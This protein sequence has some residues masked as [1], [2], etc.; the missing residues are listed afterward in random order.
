MF[1]ANSAGEE[2]IWDMQI[3]THALLTGSAA[4]GK[5]VAATVPIFAA[6]CCPDL[7]DLIIVDPTDEYTWAAQFPNTRR[8]TSAGEVN[9]CI[10]HLSREL[11]NRH[12]LLRQRNAPN[13][14]ILRDMYTA[15]LERAAEDGPAPKRLLGVFDDIASFD[16]TETANAH[17]L[18]TTQNCA[19]SVSTTLSSR[20]G[21]WL[22]VGTHFNLPS[23]RRFLGTLRTR[24]FE[25]ET[26]HQYKSG[27]L[28]PR[29]H[30]WARANAEPLHNPVIA[31]RYLPAT[32]RPSPW[33]RSIEL[34]GARDGRPAANRHPVVIVETK[35]REH[36]GAPDGFSGW[37][38]R[39]VPLLTIRGM[40]RGLHAR[41]DRDEPGS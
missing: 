31:V 7:F 41:A 20:L 18:L 32:T 16:L 25:R 23:L 10:E 8:L 9:D 11:N 4:G 34:K 39:S 19:R 5:T 3:D 24:Q 35:S 14:A 29:G 30:A 2:A 36:D 37:P 1:G 40:P 33:E 17:L 6:L 22:I 12:E 27:A 15:H 13:L 28:G 26:A 21:F 38:A